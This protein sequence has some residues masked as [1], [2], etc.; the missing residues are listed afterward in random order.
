MSRENQYLK[1]HTTPALYDT[2]APLTPLQRLFVEYYSGSISGTVDFMN[3]NDI[4]IS[5]ED[6]VKMSK[7]ASVKLA[8]KHKGKQER[9]IAEKKERQRFWS[10]VMNDTSEDM[11]N[12]LKAS[13]LLGKSEKDFVEKVEHSVETDL[14]TSIYE[15]RA[16]YKNATGVTDIIDTPPS[17]QVSAT[18]PEVKSKTLRDMIE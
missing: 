17:K 1:N 8:I 7:L 14:V 16:R 13:E 6:A 9:T 15:A 5:M 18:H 4:D 10:G 2:R 12:R 3:A 11:K